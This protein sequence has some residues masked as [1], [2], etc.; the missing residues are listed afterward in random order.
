MAKWIVHLLNA[1]LPVCSSLCHLLNVNFPIWGEY[2]LVQMPP[3]FV[4]RGDAFK[5]CYWRSG[6]HNLQGVS[7][8]IHDPSCKTSGDKAR[9]KKLH[10]W[11]WSQEPYRDTFETHCIKILRKVWKAEKEPFTCN[12]W[13]WLFLIEHFRK[14]ISRKWLNR[15]N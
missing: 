8:K 9:S 12:Y 15:K 4:H 14:C 7:K 11:T 2:N 10:L 5:A 6:V 3:S 1:G 13:D